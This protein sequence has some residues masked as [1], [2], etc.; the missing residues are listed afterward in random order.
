[1]NSPLP[2]PTAEPPVENH[3]PNVLSEREEAHLS[4]QRG[5]RI[6]AWVLW[7]AL[8]AI[9]YKQIIAIWVLAARSWPNLQ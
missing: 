7:I 2:Q 5:M 9:H 4:A 3:A 8:A 6:C 1:M